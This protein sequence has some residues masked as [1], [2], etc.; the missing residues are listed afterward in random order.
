MTE[1]RSTME[2]DIVC[3]GFGPATGGFLTTLSR[4]MVDAQGNTLLESRVMPGM[5]LQ[6]LC[7]ER[8]DDLSFGVSGVVSRARALRASFTPEELASVPMATSVTR[9]EVLYLQDPI[10]ASRRSAGVRAVDAMLDALKGALPSADHALALPWIPPFL[11]KH[12]GM[13]FSLGQLNQWVGSQ[14]MG[15]GLVQIWP[16][17]PVQEP[18]Y[19]GDRVIGVRLVDQGVE[20]NGAPTGAYM[21]GMD[22]QAALTVVGDGPVG[23]VGQQ[24]NQRFGFPKGHH[25]REW[26]IGMKAVVELAPDCG[27]EAG[28]VLHTFGYPEPE[29]FGFLY[30]HPDRMASVGIFIPSWFDSP[31]RTAYR[32]LQHWMTH[33]RLWKHLK[34]STMQ[35]WGAKTLQESGRR[36]EP[37]LVGHGYARI[38]EGSGSTNVLTGSGVDEAWATGVQ[39]AEAVIELTKAGKPYTKENLEATYVARRR[40]S[41]VDHD[42]GVAERARDGFNAGFLRGLVGMGLT[43]LT[44][45]LVNMPGKVVPPHDRLPSLERYYGDRIPGEE[46]REIRRRCLAA[47]LPVHDALMDRS[48]WPRIELDGALLVSHQDALLMGGK[49]QAAGGFAD[50][51]T[52]A[53]VATCAGCGEQVCIDGCSGQ[54]IM[55]GPDGVPVFDREK[56]IHCGVCM[57]NCS[58]PHAADAERSNVRFAAGSGGLHSPIN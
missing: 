9:E 12:D 13:I 25:Q 57:W 2:T 50:H 37:H 28:D 36:G 6:V 45:G 30:V 11:Q 19:N 52:F 31:A 32:Y 21:P 27:L 7:Y 41:W 22:V 3:V 26:A 14:L 58:K 44:R 46:I 23:P 15:S 18:L 34:G 56:C 39:L 48:G 10:G 55:P 8:A 1:V 51:V 35:S 38:G 49:V 4:A 29:I 54:A 24:L 20:R 33:P 16:G 47:G 43:G 40:A 53:D 42:A 17:M 5:P